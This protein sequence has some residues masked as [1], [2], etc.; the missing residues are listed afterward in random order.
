MFSG[1]VALK[2]IINC[3]EI[4]LSVIGYNGD[5]SDL[6]GYLKLFYRGNFVIS[7]TDRLL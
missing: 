1:G 5:K 7:P 3:F 4:N 2:L 6:G